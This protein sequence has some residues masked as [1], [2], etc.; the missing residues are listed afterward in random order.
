MCTI[1]VLLLF[2]AAF[3]GRLE[4]EVRKARSSPDRQS[5]RRG[6]VV[7]SRKN[8]NSILSRA[9]FT[10]WIEFGMCVESKQIP[11]Y[12]MVTG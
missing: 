3:R 6:I 10:S 4:E 1:R 9:P 8:R 2:K 5:A 12:G 11:A 7:S